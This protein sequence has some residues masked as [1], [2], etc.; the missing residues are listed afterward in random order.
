VQ[1]TNRYFC[2][3]DCIGG[4]KGSDGQVEVCGEYVVYIL[5]II[6]KNIFIQIIAWS[7]LFSGNDLV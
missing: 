6:L 1:G 7:H 3:L 2:W 4:A 5:Y